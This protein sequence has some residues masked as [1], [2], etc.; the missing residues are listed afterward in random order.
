MT[1]FTSFAMVISKLSGQYGK[2]VKSTDPENLNGDNKTNRFKIFCES[3]SLTLQ[4]L[5][6]LR[7]DMF[8]LPR[9]RV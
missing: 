7:V 3:L 8:N 2:V 9:R 4:R 5:R 1:T 6:Y